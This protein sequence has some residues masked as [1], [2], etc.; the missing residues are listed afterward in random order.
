MAKRKVKQINNEKVTPKE[1]KDWLKGILEFQ[2]ASWSPNTEQWDTIKEKIFSLDDE[3]VISKEVYRKE[4]IVKP[5][6]ADPPPPPLD[7]PFIHPYTS[8]SQE[9]VDAPVIGTGGPAS[10][11]LTG[12]NF[13]QLSE[14]DIKN[15][16]HLA[17]TAQHAPGAP[18][19]STNINRKFDE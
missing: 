7:R 13:P 11:L 19:A 14:Q 16:I 1:L 3:T 6:Y 9:L 18:R 12:E 17:Q 2:N 5:D 15:K 4:N 8:L 10:G